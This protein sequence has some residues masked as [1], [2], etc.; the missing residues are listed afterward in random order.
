MNSTFRSSCLVRRESNHLLLQTSR[1]GRPLLFHTYSIPSLKFNT[2]NW[3]FAVNFA[4]NFRQRKLLPLC[5]AWKPAL[6]YRKSHVSSIF[7]ALRNSI[8]KCRFGTKIHQTLRTLSNSK[9][10][11]IY[12]LHENISMFLHLG[13]FHF[14]T[15]YNI[16]TISSQTRS[17][18]IKTLFL[19]IVLKLNHKTWVCLSGL[20]AKQFIQKKSSQHNHRPFLTK[21]KMILCLI[22]I[23]LVEHLSNLWKL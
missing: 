2:R 20:F 13:R 9:H 12:A 18:R 10:V 7:Y 1:F 23:V 15:R 17:T 21:R 14:Q 8:R 4:C 16:T 19:E 3:Y 5:L 11:D 22:N 6:A